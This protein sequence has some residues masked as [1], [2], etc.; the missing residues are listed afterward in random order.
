MW[1]CW[2]FMGLGIPLAALW[3]FCQHDESFYEM[4]VSCR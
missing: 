4:I 3:A 1:V 2:K